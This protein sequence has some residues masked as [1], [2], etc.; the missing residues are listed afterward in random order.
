M[1]PRLLLFVFAVYTLSLF[2]IAWITSRRANDATFY[3]GNR[4]SPWYVVAYG[5]IG[6][7]LSGVT[8]LSEPGY[9][10]DTQFSYMMVV[11]GYV[12]GYV[13][14]SRI[15]LPLYYRL[16]LISI[17]TYLQKRFGNCTYR[18][19]AAFFILSRGV[20]AALRVFLVIYILHLFVFQHWGISFAA[21]S[22]IFI[23]LI[24]LYTFRGGI[25]TIVW[26]DTLQ[27]TFMLASVSI[28]VYLIA[29][30]MG[31]S[32]SDLFYRVKES[33]YSKMLVTDWTDKRFYL[34]Q[35]FSGI[36]I[37]IVMTGLDQDMM[38]KNLSCRNLREA[39][40]NMITLG[41]LLIPINL[42]FLLLGAVL[43]LY[44]DAQQITVTATDSLFAEIAVN[45]LG[46]FAGTVFII[47]LV[48]AAY[49][50]ADG[51]LTSLTTSFCIDI[52]GLDSMSLNNRK[53]KAV[54]YTVH[55]LFAI[56][57]LFV[58]LGF[59]MLDDKAVIDKFFIIAGYTY[60]PLL[61]FYS[62][63]LFTKYKVRDC[64]TPFVAVA[65]PLTAFVLDTHSQEWFGGYEFGYELL[66][67]NGLITF[68]GLLICK[69]Q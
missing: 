51:S 42:M 57:F 34:K 16:N 69:K 59:E 18:T 15:L 60:G 46:T 23:L 63:G 22:V 8:F 20:G 40:K 52:I 7:S 30:E 5:M 35:F 27:T 6:A 26:T 47:G 50:S 29:K 17:Y 48:A 41:W 55:L 1:S 2:V 38:Q 28:S 4:Q 54:R 21:V 58:V 19:G 49:S 44:A 36:F 24:L 62:F 25:R 33:G 56:L 61:G 14:I 68:T 9:V 67:V 31:W 12:F 13:I 32:F 65:A 11:F 43:F 10:R 53:K 45:H 37:T 64:L 3:R 39:R 66:I